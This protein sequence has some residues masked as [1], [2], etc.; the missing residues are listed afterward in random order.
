MRNGFDRYINPSKY[1][2]AIGIGIFLLA[3]LV[4]ISKLI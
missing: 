2:I 4:L 3:V 1:D